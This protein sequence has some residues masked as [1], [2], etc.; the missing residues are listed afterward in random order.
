ML[1]ARLHR[2]LDMRLEQ[3]SYP[4]RPEKGEALIKIVSSGICGSDLH[5]YKNARIGDTVV[6]TPL[7]IGHEFSGIVE[8]VWEDACD[9][10]FSK[11]TA[12][13]RVAVDPAQ[14]CGKCELCA[15]GHPNLCINLKFCGNYP[16]DGCFCQY[17]VVPSK[18]C[19]PLPDS[20]NFIEGAL[21]E[22]LGV[23]IHSI[24]LA[25]IKP[26]DSVAILGAGPIGLL[27]LQVAKIVGAEPIFVSDRFDWRLKLAAE[28]GGIPINCDGEDVIKRI[29]DETRGR[30]VDVAIESAR[31]EESNNQ[32]VEI[33]RNG[34]KVVLVGIPEDDKLLIRHSTARRKGLTILMSRRMKHTYPKAINLV[35]NGRVNLMKLVTHRFP[36][37]RIVD[38]FNLNLAYADGVVKVVI[39]H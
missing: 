35:K 19:F 9:G 18:C 24:N 1:A 14:P 29:M 27:I 33:V 3:V 10:N 36:L 6:E 17:I 26:A 31:G 20:I 13:A 4:R 22:P 16:C 8:D 11:L 34:G 15:K 32:A 37:S 30:G 5:I 38:A 12:G 2:P 7:I 28:F 25:K 21:L 39:E 23:A